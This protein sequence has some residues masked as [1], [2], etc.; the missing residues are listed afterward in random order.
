MT[1]HNRRRK[2]EPLTTKV[3]KVRRPLPEIQGD[4]SRLRKMSG[5]PEAAKELRELIQR[6]EPDYYP[7]RSADASQ[8]RMDIPHLQRYADDLR[9]RLERNES[10][11]VNL[12]GGHSVAMSEPTYKRL[13]YL[14]P[15]IELEIQ[16]LSRWVED[17]DKAEA[18]KEAKRRKRRLE[19]HP[20]SVTQ[21]G[22]EKDGLPDPRS[23]PK[24]KR[25]FGIG[26]M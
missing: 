8:I 7:L 19:R 16:T 18:E 25:R 15:V 4:L 6:S 9:E 26:R 1:L 14:L 10:G 3:E 13:K 23:K 2:E 11:D 24:P 22:W 17:F 12:P 20:G 21:K 5:R